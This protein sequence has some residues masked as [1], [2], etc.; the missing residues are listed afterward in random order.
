MK[1]KSFISAK[2]FIPII[3]MCTLLPPSG[4]AQ[5]QWEEDGIPVR[6]G[7][8]I[9]WF[10]SAASLEDGSVVYAWSDTRRGDR[11]V[12][13][14]RVDN[15]GN[16]LWGDEGVL[17]N[18]ELNRQEDPVVIDAG[19]GGVII[20]WV[21][22]RE[23]DAGDIYAQKVDP[24]GNIAWDSA[25]VPL[26]LVAGAQ[27]TLNIINDAAGGAYIIWEDNRN[28]GGTDIFGTHISAAGE[29]E[30]GWVEGGNPIAQASGIQNQ[31]TLW[32][33]GTGGAIVAWHDTREP[34]NENLYMQRIAPNG[35]LLWDEEGRILCNASGTQSNVKM[36]PDG[37]GGFIFAWRDRRYENDGDIF[38]Q[39]VNINGNLLWD[40]E[41]VE[42]Y[43]GSG[44]QRNPRITQASDPGAIIAWEDGRNHIEYFDIYGQKIGLNGSLV[45]DSR[46]IE[47]CTADNN[48]REPRLIGDTNGGC[49]VVWEDARVGGHPHEDIYIQ[50]VNADGSPLWQENGKPI[51]DAIGT[52]FSPLLRK[53]TQGKVYAVWGDNRDGSTGLYLQ[54]LDSDGTLYLTENGEIIYH[55]LCGDARDYILL[56]NG[57]N[58]VAIWVDSR[59]PYLD[60]QIFMQVIYEDGSMGLEPNGKSITTEY[61]RKKENP[62]AVLYPE[63]NCITVAWEESQVERRQVIVQSVDIECNYLWGDSGVAVCNAF[64]DQYNPHLSAEQSEDNMYDY[65]VGWTDY[66]MDFINPVN[67]VYGQKIREGELLWGEEGV[68]IG[69]QPGDDVL[70]D[71]KGRFFIWQNESWQDFDIY[72][73]LV[74]ENGNTA[75]GW[76]ENGFCICGAEG[77]QSNPRGILTEQGLLVVWEDLRN[78]SPYF[79]DI[80]G[81]LVT[82]EGTVLWDEDGVPLIAL[83][84]DQFKP[85]LLYHDEIYMAW[86]DFRSGTNYQMYMQKYEDLTAQPLWQENGSCVASKISDNAPPDIMNIENILAVAWED[87]RADTL[88][89]VYAQ[90]LSI[91]GEQLWD[92]DGIVICDA[93]KKQMIPKIAQCGE[94]S[95]VI[96]WQD[97]RSSGKQDIYNI[98]AQKIDI[99]DDGIA[100]NS[101]NNKPVL[102]QNYPNPFSTSTTISFNIP[103]HYKD[104]AKIEIYNIKGQRVKQFRIKN[105]EFKIG[106]VVW[107]G[108][109]LNG[110]QVKNGVYFYKLIAG[111]N[112]SFTKK[113]ILLR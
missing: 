7:V 30:A 95:A 53:N 29:I 86:N 26:C 62:A 84:Q 58:V 106:E 68:L 33:D 22:F 18:G 67:A 80:Y 48:Q 87:C 70:T 88:T 109:D 64:S 47:I 49:Y 76:P 63:S 3:L 12:W 85:A 60:K 52:Q 55:G 13:A 23:D 91:D 5:I 16:L 112:T 2:H 24:N 44:R 101:W 108:K 96:I 51:C 46:G 75:P 97:T 34:D 61:A 41:G 102:Y 20:A 40:D 111:D 9:E 50:H 6:Q 32:E 25:G 71:I 89:D 19:D 27:V 31:H 77:N 45:W 105:L 17:V 73:K 54:I 57:D 81:Q 1:L 42:I 21:D 56:P 8:N 66:N 28:P 103:P 43:S 11:D 69:D 113:M 100:E 14:Q 107:D 72:V 38:A 37:D 74:D 59:N 79:K 10:R 104:D 98:Y 4:Y 93:I 78:G 110:N 99:S 36:A 15:A 83:E 65:Y 94:H 39:R 90:K 35:T 92:N 82:Y